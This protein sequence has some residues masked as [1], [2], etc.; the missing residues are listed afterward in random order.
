MSNEGSLPSPVTDRRK[1]A[2]NAIVNALNVTP[3]EA[4]WICWRMMTPTSA[5]IVEAFGFM[6]CPLGEEGPGLTRFARF[7]VESRIV[8]HTQASGAGHHKLLNHVLVPVL[9]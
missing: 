9:L 1:V 8:E 2:N 3:G 6:L 4:S 7:S 5:W